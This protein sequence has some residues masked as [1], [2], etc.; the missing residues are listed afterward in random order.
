MAPKDLQCAQLIFVVR[1]RLVI[2]PEQGMYF[3]IR[4]RLVPSTTTI[5]QI[6]EDNKDQDG[7]LYINYSLENTFGGVD[8]KNDESPEPEAPREA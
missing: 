8:E 4:N 2:R 7:F 3:F 5:Q 6:Y 1:R